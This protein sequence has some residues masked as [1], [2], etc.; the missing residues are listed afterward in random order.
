MAKEVARY[1]ETHYNQTDKTNNFLHRTRNLNI[2]ESDYNMILKTKWSEAIKKAEIQIQY[3]HH[4]LDAG[5]GKHHIIQYLQKSCN[6]KL[7][8]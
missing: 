4:N 6:K 1:N 8:D 7:Q 2:Y 3:T 5:K